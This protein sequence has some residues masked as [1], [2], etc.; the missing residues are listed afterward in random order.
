MEGKRPSRPRRMPGSETREDASRRF[1]QEVQVS[2]LDGVRVRVRGRGGVS[3][4]L[5]SQVGETSSQ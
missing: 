3:V 4:G 5:G 1:S 2:L